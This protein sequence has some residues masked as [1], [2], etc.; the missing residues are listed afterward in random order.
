VIITGG[1]LKNQFK[2]GYSLLIIKKL[3]LQSVKINY[4]A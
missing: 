1:I 2:D 3:Y 4:G